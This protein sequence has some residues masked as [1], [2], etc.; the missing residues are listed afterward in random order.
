MREIKE[1]VGLKYFFK[2]K[3]YLSQKLKDRICNIIR[4]KI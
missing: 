4:N 1:R 3:T 2:N